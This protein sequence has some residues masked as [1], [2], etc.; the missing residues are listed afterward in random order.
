MVCS[1]QLDVAETVGSISSAATQ[2]KDISSALEPTLLH[3]VAC[4]WSSSNHSTR[5][6]FMST[7]INVE[8]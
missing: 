5:D 2:M 6:M 3:G 7:Q 4:F 1:L 8:T